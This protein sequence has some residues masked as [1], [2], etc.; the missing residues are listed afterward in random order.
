MPLVGF[1]PKIPAG[2]RPQ[3]YALD[4]AATGTGLPCWQY[5]SSRRST[6]WGAGAHEKPTYS[7][8]VKSRN[9]VHLSNPQAH[10][11]CH[12]CQT[13]VH[14]SHTNHAPPTHILYHMS[15]TTPIY[16]SVTQSVSFLQVYPPKTLCAFRASPHVRL[17]PRPFSLPSAQPQII[18]WAMQITKS[19]IM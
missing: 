9:S 5:E 2:E 7:V 15:Y 16:V 11:H 3:A 10:Y 17:I 1:E 19:L 18:L 4:G 13:L 6:P 8:I 12:K 14:L